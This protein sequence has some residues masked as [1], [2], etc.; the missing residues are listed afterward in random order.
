[1][2]TLS[3]IIDH[4]EADLKDSTNTSW[5]AAELQRPVRWAL[6]EVSWA[7]PRRASAILV[8]VE[9]QREYSLAA[10]G[11][12]GALFVAEVWYPYTAEDPEYPPRSVPWRLLDDDT[13]FLDVDSV[14]GGDGMRVFYAR[15]HAIEQLDGA[16]ATTLNSEQEEL[17]CLGA[18]GYAALQRA[19]DAIGRVNV[20][21]EAPRLWR[22]WGDR[23]LRDFRVRLE[24]LARRDLPWRTAWTEGWT[25]S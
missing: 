4:V 15:P 22:D 17:V 14:N 23:R 12:S 7:M 9:G 11:M 18:A 6:Q 1:M 16:A 3:E 13:L 10:A 5:S 24:R 21:G 25:P 8:A 19:Q 2:S 20:T